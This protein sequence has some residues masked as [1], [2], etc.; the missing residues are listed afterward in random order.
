MRTAE[1]KRKTRETDISLQLKLEGQGNNNIDT[2]CGFLDHMLELFSAHGGF[3]LTIKCQGDTHVDD[4]HTVEDVGIS[5]GQAFLKALG[6]KKGIYRYGSMTLP[7]DEVLVVC[8]L[9]LSGRSY[10][11]MDVSIPSQKVG[12]FDTELVSEFMMA[13]ARSLEMNLHFVL[14]AGGNSHH[15]IEGMYKAL[16]RALAQGVAIDPKNKDKIPST[17]GLL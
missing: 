15:I 12:T 17:K 3:D 9:D 5:L 8:S 11:N 16:G 14:L 4:H 13:M 10:L 7:M 1:I 2:G 6:D